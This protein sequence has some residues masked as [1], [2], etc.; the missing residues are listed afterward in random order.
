MKYLTITLTLLSILYACSYEGRE[1]ADI[2]FLDGVIYTSNSAQE[3]VDSFAIKD[4]K[5][6]FVGSFEESKPYTNLNTQKISLDGKMILPG[7]HDVHIHLPGIVKNDHCD[8]DAKRYSLDELVPILQQCI[9]RLDLPKGEWLAVTQWQYYVGNEPSEANPNLRAA[10]DNVS[11]YH[12]IMLLGHDGHTSAVN[13]FAF[14]ISQNSNGEVIGLNKQTLN[15]EFSHLKKLI[16]VDDQGNPSGLV[17][18]HARKIFK[19]HPNLW[20]HPDIDEAVYTSIANILASSGITSVLDPALQAYEIEKFAELAS[21]IELSYRMHAAFYSDYDK[22]KDP[23]S[24]KINVKKIITAIKDLQRKYNQ[25][26]NFKLNTG[27]IFVDGVLE[28]DPLANPPMLPNAASLNHYLQ[29]VFSN[30][31]NS[32]LI[33]VKSYVQGDS[34]DCN[35]V[36]KLSNEQFYKLFGFHPDQCEQ[37][38]GVLEYD[39][40]FIKEYTRELHAAGINVHSHTIGDRALRVAMDAF[41]LA[42]ES[43]GS[44]DGNFSITHAQLMH[45]DDIQRFSSIKVFIAFQYAWIEP[46]SDYLMTVA[47]FID[48]IFSEDDLYDQKSYYYRNT[49]PARS[50]Q[51]AG[52]ILAAGSDAPVETRDPR[53]F[54]NIEK[55]ITRKN[56]LTG[57]VMNQTEAISLF[58]AIDAYTINGAKMLQQDKLTGSIEIGKKADF[59]ILNQNLLAL[60]KD[61]KI[62]EISETEVLS[63]WFD[64]KEIYLK[65]IK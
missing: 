41:E 8:L 58:D 62:D 19:N 42:K 35:R 60:K 40:D 18:E 28:G 7:L 21:K 34:P 9:Q 63:T 55:A 31:S 25:I 52:A 37:S 32:D 6:I 10:L 47:P 16:G 48:P 13:S 27:K 24:E 1:Y 20:G 5:I 57:R 11:Q 44:S 56:E 45:P 65:N 3:V 14:S 51:L 61:N 12:P 23:E 53:P 4:D 36:G 2:I 38:K 39:V 22:F 26:P 29:P 50:S 43:H 46:F 49:Y 33:Y 15:R 54:L 17:K 59:I 64:G 30:P